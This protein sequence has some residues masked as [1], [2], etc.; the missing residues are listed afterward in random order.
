M[1]SFEEAFPALQV[2][3][4]IPTRDALRSTALPA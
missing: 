1:C 3:G 2:S 4:A